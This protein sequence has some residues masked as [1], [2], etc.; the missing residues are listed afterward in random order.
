MTDKKLFDRYNRNLSYLRV[1]IT[2]RC[3]LNCIYCK[4]EKLSPKL[5]HHEILSYE[6]ILRI[7][8]VGSELGIK[9]IRI[10]GGEPLTKKGVYNFLGKLTKIDGIDDVSLT[11]NGVYLKENIRKIQD[12]GIK[13]INIS[14]DTLIGKR[15]E[16]ITGFDGLD[17]VLK[18]IYAALDQGFDPVKINVVALNGINDD[19]FLSLARL[20]VDHPFH[21]RFI[22]YMPIG[23]ARVNL[24]QQILADKIMERIRPLGDLIS[25]QKEHNDGPAERYKLKNA[26]GEIGFIRPVS[27]HFCSTCNR[28]RLTASGKLRSCLL[29]NVETDIKT[30]LRSGCSDRELYNVYLQAIKHKQYEHDLENQPDRKVPSQMSSIGG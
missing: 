26:K 11:T 12:A 25:I 1:S 9:K 29:S 18:G 6:E 10:T 14:L 23:E 27:R 5:P 17:T 24:Q 21:I 20:S 7:A 8:H 19:E 28:L 22:E 3:N 4:P 16:Q 13:R 30:P 15:Y 2:D